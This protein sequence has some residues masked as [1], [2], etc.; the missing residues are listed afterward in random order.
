MIRGLLGLLSCQLVGTFLV[1]A[2]HLKVPG[3]VLGMLLLLLLLI[4]R[5]PDA[6]ADVLKAGNRVLDELPLLF[7]PA[8]VGVIGCLGMIRAHWAVLSVGLVLPWA[9]GLIVTTGAASLVKTMLV[10]DTDELD[11]QAD[12]LVGNSQRMEGIEPHR[13][14][15]EAGVEQ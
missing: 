10:A 7:I 14:T 1:S 11:D 8:G 2:F 5:K 12:A 4:W 9:A 3:S 15:P 6:D 13:T